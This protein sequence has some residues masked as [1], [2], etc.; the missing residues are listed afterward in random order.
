MASQIEK[1]RRPRWKWSPIAIQ[2]LNEAYKKNRFPTREQRLELSR[3]CNN[4]EQH[5]TGEQNR[6]V[7]A[8][9]DWE[10]INEAR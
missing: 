5:L 2:I 7:L 9:G 8:D 4:A 10:R 6:R 3:I 1:R